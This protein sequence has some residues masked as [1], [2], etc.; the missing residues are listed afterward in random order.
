MQIDFLTCANYA[1]T[2]CIIRALF[3]KSKNHRLYSL[4]AYKCRPELHVQKN[5][6]CTLIVFGHIIYE[7][8]TSRKGWTYVFIIFAHNSLEELSCMKPSMEVRNIAQERYCHWTLKEPGVLLWSLA[9]APLFTP[10]C[11]K[12]TIM[13]FQ[14]PCPL[15]QQSLSITWLGNAYFTRSCTCMPAQATTCVS[16]HSR[17]WLNLHP[18]SAI[19]DFSNS[20]RLQAFSCS[21]SLDSSPQMVLPIYDCPHEQGTWYTTKDCFS[22]GKGSFTLVI[23]ERID[24]AIFKATLT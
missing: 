15:K 24:L 20:P 12:P 11:C 2:S 22:H 14:S 4:F 19:V 23:S 9:L 17:G 21:F 18:R 3:F 5:V 7:K 16:L 1:S 10:D 13:E 6:M 8:P